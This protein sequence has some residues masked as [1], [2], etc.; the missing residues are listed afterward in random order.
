MLFLMQD[1]ILC[2]YRIQDQIEADAK[3]SKGRTGWSPQNVFIKQ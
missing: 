2:C 3:G 1:G